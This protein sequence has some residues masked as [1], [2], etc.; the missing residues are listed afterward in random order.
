VTANNADI[1]ALGITGSYTAANKVY[2]GNAVAV[3]SAPMLSGVLAGDGVTLTGGAG[4]FA[5]KNVGTN[6]TVTV[7]GATLDRRRCAE[8]HA[9]CGDGEQCRHHGARR[10]WQLSPLRSRVYNGNAVA[11]SRCRS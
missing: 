10:D 4:A 9:Q 6:K 11:R 5:N 1:T 3:L 8:L 2:N 7:T